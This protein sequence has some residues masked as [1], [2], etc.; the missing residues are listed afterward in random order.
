MVWSILELTT[1]PL[2][3]F[4]VLTSN[5][6][7]SDLS[8]YNLKT[9]KL[10]ILEHKADRRSLKQSPIPFNLCE[11]IIFLSDSILADPIPLT[12]LYKTLKS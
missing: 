9:P 1:T 4:K 12:F 10:A 7:S 6:F 3:H 11:Y 5:A 2:F 8:L